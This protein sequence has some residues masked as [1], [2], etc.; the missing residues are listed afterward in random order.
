MIDHGRV[1]STLIPEAKVMDD[2]SVWVN[3]DIK[4]VHITDEEGERIEYEFNQVQYSKNE[5]IELISAQNAE[6]AQELTNTQLALCDIYEMMGG[7][8]NG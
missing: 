7:V 6:I 4:E 8:L 1:R 3:S 2:Y 5:Y